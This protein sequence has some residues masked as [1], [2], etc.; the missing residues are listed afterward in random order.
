[1]D[2]ACPQM[3]AEKWARIERILDK[4]KVKP[5]VGVIPENRD[6]DF[7]AVADEN[8]WG[9]ACEWQ[10]KG[11]TIALHGLHHELHF[12]EPR[13]Y[14]QLS[15]SSKTEWA[16]KSSTEQYETSVYKGYKRDKIEMRGDR[17]EMS[18]FPLYLNTVAG[19]LDRRDQ[20]IGGFSFVVKIYAVPVV[21]II[22]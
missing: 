8:F 9:K 13:G 4:Y 20:T 7:V 16:G 2:D 12:H 14:Y 19:G 21:E 5:I 11:W 6:P 10:K 1:M 15:H 18:D 3:N 22:G 17:A